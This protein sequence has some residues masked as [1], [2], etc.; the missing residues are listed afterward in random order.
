MWLLQ[1][2]HYQWNETTFNNGWNIISV[3]GSKDI[4]ISLFYSW[5]TSTCFQ[6][7]NS[8]GKRNA[9]SF[10]CFISLI[11][12]IFYKN[13]IFFGLLLKQFS[14]KLLIHPLFIIPPLT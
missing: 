8:C 4:H 5:K 13:R 10:C 2:L 3:K 7:V 1:K 14:V 9:S 11:G 12:V 6:V